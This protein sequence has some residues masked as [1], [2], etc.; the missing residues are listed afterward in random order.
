MRDGFWKKGV[1]FG[2]SLLLVLLILSVLVSAST[3]KLDTG[4]PSES[5]VFVGETVLFNDVAFMIR[6]AEIIPVDYLVFVIFNQSDDEEV[7]SVSFSL[8]GDEISGSDPAGVF[9]VDNVTN[10]SNLPYQNGGSG[11]GYGYGYG[12]GSMD[13]TVVYTISYMTQFPG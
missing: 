10:T 7:A 3:V 5:K 6:K 9:I 8:I 1:G 11:Y 12:Y 13:L 4:A 2:V